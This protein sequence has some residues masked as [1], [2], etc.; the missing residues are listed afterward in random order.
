[1]EFGPGEAILVAA[2]FLVGFGNAILG[3]TGGLLLATMAS[4]LPP[5]LVVPAHAVL[6]ALRNGSAWY[7]LRRSFSLQI[8]VAAGF[9]SLLAIG[10]VAPFA[11]VVP[12]HVQAILIGAFLIWACWWPAPDPGRRFPFRLPLASSL[13][14]ASSV[15]L[16]ETGPL[17][18]PFIADEPVDPNL[19]PGTVNAVAAIQHGLKVLA[20]AVLGAAYLPLLPLLVAMVVA[21]ALGMALAARFRIR[22]PVVLASLLI[23]LVVTALALRLLAIAV[24][25][26]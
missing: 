21:G 24:G 1:M 3:S 16:G 19:V 15:F 5:P 11:S 9:G 26:L 23:R 8:V 13:T 22:L 10:L 7:R 20:F 2:A 18:R 17:L 12:A 4:I 25:W 6:E 14:G